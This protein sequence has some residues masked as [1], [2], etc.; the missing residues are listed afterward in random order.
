MLNLPTRTIARTELAATS[1]T[2]TLAVTTT[3]LPFTARH[4]VIRFNGQ[5]SGAVDVLLRLNAD[6]GSNYNRQELTGAA[7]S[8][9]AVRSTGETSY[10]F[11]RSVSTSNIFASGEILIPDALSTRS[12]KSLL[13]IGGKNEAEVRLDA[14]RW[15]STSAVTSVTVFPASGNFAV[16]TTIELAVVDEMFAIP[17]A[18]TIII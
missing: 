16:G 3:G 1:T 11:V 9:A 18:E 13:S 12:H 7:S 14:G 4:L 5:T 10:E 15:A 6:S 8:A 2:E 17:G